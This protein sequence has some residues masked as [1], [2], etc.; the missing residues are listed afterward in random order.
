M[1]QADIDDEYFTDLSDYCSDY[2][3][4]E[5]RVSEDE[6]E[7]DG[8]M[9]EGKAAEVEEIDIYA[10]LISRFHEHRAERMSAR[11]EAHKSLLRGLIGV[12]LFW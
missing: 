7:E 1:F 11:T 9:E 2:Y 5:D 8:E 3:E 10:D 6:D 4:Y 12:I